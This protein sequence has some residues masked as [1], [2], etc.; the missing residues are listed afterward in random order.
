MVA[1]YDAIYVKNNATGGTINLLGDTTLYSESGEAVELRKS[2][3][4]LTLNFSDT[5]KVSYSDTSI[6]VLPSSAV[7]AFPADEDGN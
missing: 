4:G 2:G 7:A 1:V 6:P 3:T 5:V